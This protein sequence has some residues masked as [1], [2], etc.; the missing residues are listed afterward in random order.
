MKTFG[1]A[2]RLTRV[3]DTAADAFFVAVLQTAHATR[4][5]SSRWSN[6][7]ARRPA[8]RPDVAGPAAAQTRANRWFLRPVRATLDARAPKKNDAGARWEVH[9][10][11]QTAVGGTGAAR[12]VRDASSLVAEQNRKGFDAI[13][14]RPSL[15][16][17][18]KTV[19]FNVVLRNCS[20]S[21]GKGP[22]GGI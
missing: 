18:Q 10:G 19:N 5:L 13:R 22:L 6:R 20:T 4:Y 16:I 15:Q 17:S 9:G 14:I 3:S 11:T 1:R 21:A 7:R 12:V 8:R 2:E